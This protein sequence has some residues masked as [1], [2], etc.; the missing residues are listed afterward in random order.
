MST[1]PDM[2]ITI[3]L[4]PDTPRHIKTRVLAVLLDISKALLDLPER[5]RTL[6]MSELLYALDD[7]GP[8]DQEE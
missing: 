3:H 7:W 4:R 8:F 5:D 6:I 1:K 2:A